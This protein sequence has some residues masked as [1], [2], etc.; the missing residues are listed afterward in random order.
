MEIIEIGAVMAEAST[1]QVFDEFQTFIRPV[2]HP[3]LTP[4]CTSLTSFEQQDIDV[5]R[6]APQDHQH[7]DLELGQRHGLLVGRQRALD[8]DGGVRRCLRAGVLKVGGASGGRGLKGLIF[9]FTRKFHEMSVA[10]SRTSGKAFIGSMVIGLSSGIW[11]NRAM[12]ISFGMPLT[13]A[14]HEPHLPALQFQRQARS[15]A[16]A[17]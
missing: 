11:L 12:H 14:E 16:F 6:L 5:G 9:F 10:R 1:F 2:R 8:P 15:L 3:R 7:D 17:A 13:S 4:F